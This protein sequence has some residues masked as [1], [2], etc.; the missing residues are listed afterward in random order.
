MWAMLVA[1]HRHNQGPS[2][3]IEVIACPGLGTLTGRVEPNEAARQNGVG[4]PALFMAA[5]FN[6]LAV[7]S[8][9]T[10]TR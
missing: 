6:Q 9:Q 3:K 8:R 1:V 5:R 10:S 4:L 7:C 2:R